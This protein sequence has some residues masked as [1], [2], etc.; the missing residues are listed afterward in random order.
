MKIKA[1][2]AAAAAVI[3]VTAAHAAPPGFNQP[4]KLEVETQQ[5]PLEEYIKRDRIVENR[6]ESMNVYALAK[7][8]YKLRSGHMLSLPLYR[9]VRKSGTLP[10][11][12]KT[13]L[14]QSARAHNLEWE[15]VA[16]VVM[17]ESGFNPKAVS[18]KGAV[19]LMQLMP[20][21]WLDLGVRDPLDPKEN[22]NAGC[23]YIKQQLQHFG[24][25]RL[26]LA[27]YNAGPGNVKKAGGVPAFRETE[28]FIARVL[29]FYQQYKAAGSL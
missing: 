11:A 8:A 18:H 28:N 2:A 19:G 29:G 6:I 25:V 20:D 7:S 23:A 27:A 12:I 15:L 1:A 22:L 26:A 17:T 24:D 4:P 16:A 14:I 13:Q 9:S 21:T 3:A 5:I 10:E